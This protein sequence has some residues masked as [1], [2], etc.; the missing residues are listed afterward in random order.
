MA[1]GALLEMLGESS[2]GEETRLSSDQLIVRVKEH[3]PG[4]VFQ[5]DRDMTFREVWTSFMDSERNVYRS[6]SL[7]SLRSDLGGLGATLVDGIAMKL[8]GVP[9][10]RFG[11][12]ECVRGR[13]RSRVVPAYV[14]AVSQLP[15]DGTEVY[16]W[17]D[18]NGSGSID[19][20]SAGVHHVM[21]DT[22]AHGSQ[23][24]V[25]LEQLPSGLPRRDEREAEVRARLA[26]RRTTVLGLGGGY[27]LTRERD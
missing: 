26:G 24:D 27:A 23:L 5:Y 15:E 12:G 7:R 9:I 17:R 19:A 1:Y 22:L 6:S 21:R 18:H 4:R 13:D 14:A 11:A 20:V 2:I 3:R 8:D 10:L 25:V 16:F